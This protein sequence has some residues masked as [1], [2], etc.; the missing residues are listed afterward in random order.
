VSSS[1]FFNHSGRSALFVDFLDFIF[2]EAA[3]DEVFFVREEAVARAD[4]RLDACEVL[5]LDFFNGM[6]CIL[7]HW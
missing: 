6:R 1:L 4:D 2:D 3:F 5:L 7:A